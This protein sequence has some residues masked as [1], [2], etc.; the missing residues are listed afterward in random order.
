MKTIRSILLLAIVATLSSSCISRTTS[1]SAPLGKGED[2][3]VTE[4]KLVWIW[5]DEF[6]NP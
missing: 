4:K 2:G 3:K 1:T 6:R 5:Q